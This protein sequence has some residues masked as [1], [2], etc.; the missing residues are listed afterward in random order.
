[1]GSPALLGLPEPLVVSRY[2][3]T[4]IYLAVEGAALGSMQSEKSRWN[5]HERTRERC[6]SVETACKG[7]PSASPEDR[8]GATSSTLIGTITGCSAAHAADASPAPVPRALRRL[9]IHAPIVDW[10][11]VILGSI[12]SGADSVIMHWGHRGSCH[13]L[14]T[15]R[16]WN[17]IEPTQHHA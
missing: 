8:D 9:T 16:S 5:R 13:Y 2:R 1:M 11:K 7:C 14:P 10:S 17:T 15:P 3:V 12:Y 6:H 4:T